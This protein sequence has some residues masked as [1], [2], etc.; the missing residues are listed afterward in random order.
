MRFLLVVVVIWTTVAQADESL[1]RNHVAPIFEARCVACHEG[2][3]PKGGLSLVSAKRFRAG[4]DSGPVVVAGRPDESRLLE[5]ISGDEP[6][7]PKDDVPLSAADVAAIRAWIEAGA[8]WPDGVE[9][10]D[11]KQRDRDW[12]SLRPLTR[13]SPPAVHSDW[14]R[15]PIDAFVLAKLQEQELSLSAAADR[16][17]L[18]RRL[19]FDLVGLPPSYE[20]VEAF[21]TD[22]DPQAYEKLVDRLLASPHYGER[23]GRHWLDVVHYGDTHGYDKDKLRPNAWPYRDYVIRAFNEDKPYSRF[24]AEQ[25]AGD[26]LYPGTADGIIATGFLVAGPFDFVGHIEV[27]E[28]TLAK[29]ITR[30]LDRDDMVSTTIGT[31]NSMTAHCARCHNHKFDPITQEDYYSLQAV[32]AGIDRADRAYGGDAGTATPQLV[33]AAATDF[34]P[35]NQFVP[36]KGEPRPVHVLN[37]GNEK[38]PGAEVGPGACGYLPDLG[39][40]FDV[41]ET[42]G[43]GAR[44]ASLASWLV[45]KRN[46]L[47]WRSIVN[48]VWQ[49]HFGRGIVDSPNDFGRMGAMPTHPELLDWLAADFRDGPQSI[50]QL[51]RLICTSAVYRQASAGNAEFETRDAANQF[52]W[53]MNRRRLEAETVRDSVLA[54][55]GKLSATQGGP[56]YRAFAFGDD[57]SPHYNY[58]GYD[59]D[60]PL[61]HRRSVYRLIVRSVPDP[62]MATLDCADASAP[63]AKRNETVTPLQ[64]L[65]LLNNKFMVRMA[66]HLAER[67]EPMGDSNAERLTAAWRLAFGR[68]PN[69][70]ELSKL[71]E[72]AERHGLANA[73]R[74]IFNM[75]E[76]VFVD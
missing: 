28:G 47:T 55:A 11:K 58:D 9:L 2:A 29:A 49:Y 44:R 24:V 76:F 6:Q 65:A 69:E 31:F 14:V 40:R 56:G 17:T 42:M 75:N 15:T 71:V 26:V 41:D 10:F 8:K 16:R 30:N 4:G 35:Q 20:E 73:C 21:V 38:D 1:F 52:L 53:R 36:T 51:H 64:S 59:P 63:V 60:D 33:F 68:D 23:W 46:P 12:W 57:E 45:D 34:A 48:R 74:L 7:M 70:D 43:E 72:Y 22:D 61:S 50:K 3:K 25:V 5:Y 27:V 19:Y 37:R 67:V 32:F 13:P 62:F 18:I 66:E 39:S 54:V